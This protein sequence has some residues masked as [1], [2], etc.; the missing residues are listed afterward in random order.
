MSVLI[1]IFFIGLFAVLFT[2]QSSDVWAKKGKDRV[3][4][5]FRHADQNG[6]GRLSH[7]EWMR[8]GN[9]ELLDQNGDGYLTLKEVK[10][11]Y[12]GHTDTNYVWPPVG[13]DPVIEDIDPS[14]TQ[15]KVSI[16]EL[17]DEMICGL[18]RLK[19]CKNVA[20]QKIRGLLETGTGPVFSDTVICPAVDDYWAMDYASKRNRASFHGGVD[21]PVAW[22]TPMRVVAAGSVVA[23][24]EAHMS[25][26][27][28]EVVVRHSPEQTGLPMWTY[29]AY[30]HLDKLP[31]FK[32][33]QRLKM[34]DVV[35]PTGNSGISARGGKQSTSRRPAIHL[36]MFQSK[37]PKYAEVNNTIVPVDGYW[38][39]PLAFYRQKPPF[40]S[41]DVKALPDEDKGVYIPL[42]TS[43][44]QTI[45]TKTKL[46]WP[47]SCEIK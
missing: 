23:I 3:K 6:D 11:M 41:E 27:G 5:D 44:G 8:R 4:R 34:G 40:K 10:K 33:G 39:D 32:I 22:G 17:S 46:I 38:L 15:D 19:R 28:N 25:K 29:T 30:G 24:Y 9:F 42:M 7:E 14:I 35:G 18:A 16:S 43:N 2:M 26:R 12:E 13:F 36:A 31:D 37:S 21:I 20:P 1:R 45:P 47:Y